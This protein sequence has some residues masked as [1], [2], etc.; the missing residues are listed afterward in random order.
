MKLKRNFVYSALQKANQ[1]VGNAVREQ[2]GE[3]AASVMTNILQ[4]TESILISPQTCGKIYIYIIFSFIKLKVFTVCI[5]I[6]EL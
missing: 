3:E 4:H 2:C 6:Y 1:C 5:K